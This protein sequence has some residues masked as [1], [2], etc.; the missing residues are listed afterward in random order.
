MGD[1]KVFKLIEECRPVKGFGRS[2]IYDLS[3]HKFDFI[4]NALFDILMNEE[5][6]CI[7]DIKQQY[8]YSPVLEE[9]FN[10]L[11]KEEYILV[12]DKEDFNSFP[13]MNLKWQHPSIITN[14][15]VALDKKSNYNL[16]KI[17]AQLEGLGCQHVLFVCQDSFDLDYFQAILNLFVTSS[18]LSIEIQ[19]LFHETLTEANLRVL[20]E[21]H[22]RINSI[23]IHSSPTNELIKTKSDNNFWGLIAFTT[24]N[25]DIGKDARSN[26]KSN[27]NVNINLFTESQEHNSYYNRKVIIQTDGGISN[28]H[29]PSSNFGHIHNTTILQAMEKSGFQDLWYTHKEKIEV[30]KDCEFRH[31][32]MDNRIPVER[33]DG[34]WYHENECFYN[35]HLSKWKGEVGYQPIR[36]QKL[37]VL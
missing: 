12:C 25:L 8:E 29:E 3:R 16:S 19:T 37:Q 30:C 22:I 2:V 31:M 15:V 24:D 14:A 32:C 23:V 34:I 11:V 26:I 1:D 9:Y 36:N 6:K 27:F 20:I 13:Q 4:P 33:K 18:F 28:T 5:G 17:I 10:F 35:P 7:G 21:E